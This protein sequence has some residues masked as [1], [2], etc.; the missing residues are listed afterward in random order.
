MVVAHVLELVARQEAARLFPSAVV[1]AV[2]AADIVR[3]VVVVERTVAVPDRPCLVDPQFSAAGG[4]AVGAVVIFI[5]SRY[6]LEVVPTRLDLVL[7]DPR[8]AYPFCKGSAR[9]TV[10]ARFT[11]PNPCV[12]PRTH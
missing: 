7:A 6:E 9:E 8:E 2:A 4:D 12:R 10:S 3:D 5:V 11:T 1:V